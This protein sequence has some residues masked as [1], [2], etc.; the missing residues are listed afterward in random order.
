V[1]L[2][3]KIRRFVRKHIKGY[4]AYLV[5][6]PKCGR[7]WLRLQIGRALQQ[8]FQLAVSNPLKL[9]LMSDL[10][11]AVPRV[12]HAHE[13]RPH[14]KKPDQ[15]AASKKSY[16]GKRVVFLVRDPRDVIVSYYFHASRRRSQKGTRYEGTIREFINEETGSFDSLLRYYAVWG[17][18]GHLTKDFL[19]VRYEDMHANPHR[20]LRRVLDFI[21]LP[22]ATDAVVN[23]AVEYASFDHMK[24]MEKKG[25]I[26]TGA[27]RPED[28]DDPDSYKVRRG[29][30]GGYVDYLTPEEVGRLNAKMRAVLPDCYGYTPNVS[31]PGD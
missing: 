23:E 22:G 3:Q 19:L 13:G 15:L 16:R 24:E 27:L 8:H 11:P 1:R 2:L 4:D 21:G 30:I 26:A 7:T 14:R 10:S 17:R 12:F 5:S 28:K 29:K 18:D 6:F 20:E 25:A 31:T 9:M